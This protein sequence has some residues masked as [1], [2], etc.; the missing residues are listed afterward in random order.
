MRRL[1]F[2]GFVLVL[3]SPLLAC[4]EADSGATRRERPMPSK[5]VQTNRPTPA[6]N[7]SAQ[8]PDAAT[9]SAEEIPVYTY[10]V[11]NS[12]PH[13]PKAF[14]QGL[15]FYD[16]NLYES[17]GHHGF[18]SL[19]K[20]ELKTGKVKKK[21][22]VPEEYFAEGI[23]IFQGKIFQLT[24]QSHKC[25]IYD[26]KSFDL[27]GEFHHDGEGWGLTHDSQYLIMSDGSNQLQ[28]LD[29]NTFLPVRTI[30][31][32]ENNH[33]LMDL[34]E[35]EYIK[36]EIYANIWHSNRIV[37]IDP[38][39]G[40]ILAWIDLTGLRPSDVDD[41]IDNVLNGIAY[42]EKEDRLFVTGKRWTKLFEIRLKRK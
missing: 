7:T 37:R 15:V 14:T 33:P 9:Q 13:D 6:P 31:V 10:E 28:F 40:R 34:N 16:G 8:P 36:G 27:K 39:T 17:T 20:V 38:A 18:S 22:D 21:Y 42:D 25:F 29:T 11:V 32:F 4:G 30:G 12:W 5:T 41:N 35:L 23:A 19:R 24:W 26:L 2:G 1:S 3:I